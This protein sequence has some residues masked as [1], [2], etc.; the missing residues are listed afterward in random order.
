MVSP[1]GLSH[2]P[3][4]HL[5][6][7]RQY[8]FYLR[9]LNLAI[10]VKVYIV[11]YLILPLPSTTS[12][13]WGT[14]PTQNTPRIGPRHHRACLWS[15]SCNAGH[16]RNRFRGW[17]LPGWYPSLASLS[18]CLKPT[19]GHNTIGSCSQTIV[20]WPTYLCFTLRSMNFG[21]YT[22]RYII[23]V[24][25]SSL[26]PKHITTKLPNGFQKLHPM[27]FSFIVSTIYFTSSSLT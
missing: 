8:P 9:T 27:M 4:H 25:W 6:Q 18:H 3:L 16:R 11:Q 12:P 26:W 21:Y 15:G 14:Y 23:I 7:L 13:T 1:S 10:T 17:T 5:H 24:L 2:L 20:P 22:P 19:S